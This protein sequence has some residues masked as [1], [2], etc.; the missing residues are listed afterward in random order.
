MADDFTK[1][2]K[3]YQDIESYPLSYA[4]MSREWSLGLMDFFNGY[5]R[6]AD[7]YYQ[8]HKNNPGR[9]DDYLALYN[10]VMD[11]LSGAKNCLSVMGI[12]ME[13]WSNDKENPWCLATKDM[14]KKYNDNLDDDDDTVQPIDKNQYW[15][16]PAPEHKDRQDR[17]DANS[18]KRNLKASDYSYNTSSSWIHKNGYWY[19]LTTGDILNDDGSTGHDN[20]YRKSERVQMNDDIII[21][22]FNNLRFPT[23]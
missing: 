20:V 21:P 18:K 22:S 16:W 12:K 5:Q 15:T 13:P 3:N 23:D 8:K 19:N 1:N 2:I 17:T 6:Q 14:A 11:Q 9:H 7:S 4:W 10:H